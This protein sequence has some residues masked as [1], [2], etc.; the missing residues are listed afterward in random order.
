MGRACGRGGARKPGGTADW[1]G[2]EGAGNAVVCMVDDI[3]RCGVYR[4]EKVEEED[5]EDRRYL[6]GDEEMT[7][8][9]KR[10]R[11]TA[12]LIW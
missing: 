1:R 12:F 2:R 7:A 5:E 10:L 9:S 8:E 3:G 11:R 6:L 4:R